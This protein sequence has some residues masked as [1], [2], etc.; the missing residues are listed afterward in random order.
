MP[1]A[2]GIEIA[3]CEPVYATSTTPFHARLLDPG[4]HRKFGGGLTKPAACGS[5][6]AWDIDVFYT[7]D[8][9]I[10]DDRLCVGCREALLV[11]RRDTLTA[12][13]S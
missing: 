3:L 12:L 4:E 5:D 1:T 2:C 8:E 10:A 7:L 6:V 13:R 9:A 11:L